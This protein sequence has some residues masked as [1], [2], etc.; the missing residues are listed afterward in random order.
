VDPSGRYSSTMMGGI[1]VSMAAT[2]AAVGTFVDKGGLAAL[3]QIVIATGL[4]LLGLF[5]VLYVLVA[6]KRR[7][8]SA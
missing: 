5:M 8:C 1:F 7:D 2:P 3:S 6:P 4:I